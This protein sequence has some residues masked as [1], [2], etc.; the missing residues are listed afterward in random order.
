MANIEERLAM[1]S[2]RVS[3][4]AW[5]Q[6]YRLRHHPKF[7]SLLSALEQIPGTIIPAHVEQAAQ[8]F[9]DGDD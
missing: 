6:L 2:G 8:N 7:A 3:K 5:T 1:L 4:E 9:L